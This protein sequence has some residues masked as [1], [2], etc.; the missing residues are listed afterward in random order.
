M[1]KFQIQQ[2]NYTSQ[3]TAADQQQVY[4]GDDFSIEEKTYF[5]ELVRDGQA[6][7]EW[8]DDPI[9]ARVRGQDGE[10]IAEGVEFF[11]LD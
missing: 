1:T 11:S 2:L 7:I 6:T 9:D 5:L 4:G 8:G 3:L 10:V